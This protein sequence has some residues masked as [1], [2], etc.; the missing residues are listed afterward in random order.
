M[1]MP[2]LFGPLAE[3]YATRPGGYTRLSRI[4]F[5]NN[6]DRADLC[7]VELVDSSADSKIALEEY[8]RMKSGGKAGIAPTQNDFAIDTTAA[9]EAAT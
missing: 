1:T 8:A 5:S 3:R 7:R 2:L 6:L 9:A 4:G